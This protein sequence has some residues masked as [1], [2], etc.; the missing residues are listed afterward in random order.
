M[1]LSCLEIFVEQLKE[2]QAN[3]DVKTGYLLQHYL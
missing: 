1:P 3:K 2:Y